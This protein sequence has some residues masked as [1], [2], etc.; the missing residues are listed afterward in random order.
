MGT[1]GFSYIGL[2]FL[3]MLFVPNILWAKQPPEGYEELERGE[4]RWLLAFER[5]GQVLC[6]GCALCFADLNPRGLSPWVL[7]LAVSFALMVLYEAC[8][9]RYFAGPRTVAAFYADQFGI[10]VPLATL[11]VAAFFLLGVYGKLLWLV[12]AAVILGVGHIG[13]HLRHR[14]EVLA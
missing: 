12:L 11:P 14:R 3:V 2:V 4:P 7:I 1:F 5:A 10:P 6:T 13:I 8:W 9:Y